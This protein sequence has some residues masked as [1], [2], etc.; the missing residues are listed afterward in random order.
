MF[1]V[2]KVSG[3]HRGVT[4][5]KENQERNVKLMQFEVL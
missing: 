1:E 3:R 2:I 4:L 5:D